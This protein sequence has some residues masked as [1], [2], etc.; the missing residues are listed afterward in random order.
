MIR[1]IP[2]IQVKPRGNHPKD[3]RLSEIKE[4]A[5]E[6]DAIGFSLFPSFAARGIQN[7]HGTTDE[8]KFH[9]KLV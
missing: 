3:L 6:R 9:A 5:E 7:V 4:S 2:A 8:T 1:P